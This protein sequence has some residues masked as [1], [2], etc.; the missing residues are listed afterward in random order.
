MAS[1]LEWADRTVN[2]HDPSAL[3]KPLEEMSGR[4]DI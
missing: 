1:E 3:L 2:S 4:P